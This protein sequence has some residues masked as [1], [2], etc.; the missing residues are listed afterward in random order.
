MSRYRSISPVGQQNDMA[1]WA[2]SLKWW[3]KAAKSIDPSQ[4][5]L[6][7]RYKHLRDSQGGMTESGIEHIIN[8][9]GM[10]CLTYRNLANLDWY[11]IRDL[12]KSFGPIYVAFTEP[13][14]DQKKHVNV[15]YDVIGDGPWAEVGV[16]E[17]QAIDN[18]DGTFTG[19]HQQRSL[20][21]YN[22]VGATFVGVNRAKW[23]KWMNS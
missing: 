2:A 13:G 18:D 15:I 16:M 5:K 9:N 19:E 20:S 7:E 23:S 21:D 3:Y 14:P 11:R 4:D 12:V 17:P 1:C 10:K 8:E 22:S 6:W